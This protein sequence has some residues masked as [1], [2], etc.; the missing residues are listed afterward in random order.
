[1]FLNKAFVNR[2]QQTL[3]DKRPDQK[4]TFLLMISDLHINTTSNK[5]INMQWLFVYYYNT[6]TGSREI[7]LECQNK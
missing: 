1:M 5:N 4:G 7:L 6:S 2:G 3:I